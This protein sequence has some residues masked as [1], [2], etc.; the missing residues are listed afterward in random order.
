MQPLVKICGLST[1]ATVDAVIEG[2]AGLVGFIFFAKSPR[3]VS[4]SQA[5]R[6][7]AGF[8]P[9]KSVAVT[10]DSDNGFL[11]DIVDKMKPGFLQLHGQESTA[12]LME[13]KHRY[14]LPLIK[15]LSV[16][17]PDD[18]DRVCEYETCA[19]M[20]LLDAMPPEGSDLPGGNGVQFDWSLV[21]SFQT[22]LP[23]LLSGGIDHSNVG[24]ALS[25]VRNPEC[26]IIGIDVSSGVESAPGVKDLRKIEQLLATCQSIE[27]PRKKVAPA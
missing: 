27:I 13:I 1:Q 18:L 10:V 7:V 20:V 14:E 9:Q 11:D 6:L 25:Y 21:A 24:E 26:S 2:G 5:A 17:E 23:V 16:R 22:S 3:N 8:G 4:P 12:R 19:D 15:A